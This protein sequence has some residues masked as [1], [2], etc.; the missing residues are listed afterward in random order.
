MAMEQVVEARDLK[1]SQHVRF[2]G[3]LYKA[4]AVNVRY[5][6]VEVSFHGINDEQPY[7]YELTDQF[8]VVTPKVKKKRMVTR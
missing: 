8:I 7:T 3:D 5:D 4:R 2:Y 1:P 6:R